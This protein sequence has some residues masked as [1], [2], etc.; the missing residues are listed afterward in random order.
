MYMQMFTSAENWTGKLEAIKLSSSSI[1]PESTR[2]RMNA[3]Y[4]GYW[5]ISMYSNLMETLTR[6]LEQNNYRI[7]KSID[8]VNRPFVGSTRAMLLQGPGDVPI[9]ILAK[10][11]YCGD[12]RTRFAG[13]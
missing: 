8:T 13:M 9:E 7:Q 12:F 3:G 1:K 2:E 11:L 6:K 10:S 4:T 5:M